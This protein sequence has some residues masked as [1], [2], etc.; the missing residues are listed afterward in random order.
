MIKKCAF[1]ASVLLAIACEKELDVDLVNDNPKLVINALFTPDSTWMVDLTRNAHILDPYPTFPAVPDA[2][3]TIVNQNNEIVETLSYSKVKDTR[4]YPPADRGV[5]RGKI[6]PVHGQV[7][8][9]KAETNH[10]ASVQATGRVPSAVH[11]T[12]LETDS[13]H[14]QSDKKIEMKIGFSDRSDE[15][16]YY[17]IKILMKTKVSSWY[18]ASAGAKDTIRTSYESEVRLES[19]DES[20][21]INSGTIFPDNYFNGKAKTVRFNFQVSTPYTSPYSRQEYTD[22]RIVLM[23]VSEE[24]YKYFTSI[25][26]YNDSND[27]PLAQPVQIFNNIENG[28]GIFAGYSATMIRLK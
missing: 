8:T 19:I 6:V 5:Y 4:S 15:K 17:Q 21:E 9:I 13:S 12:L 27:N 24:Y 11:L 1:I 3:V 16:N 14:Y 20:P 26:L 23:N 25:N 28:F 7:Y 22:Y 18:P 2:V 10:T